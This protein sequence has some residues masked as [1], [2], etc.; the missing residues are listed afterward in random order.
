M[1]IS[2]VQSVITLQNAAREHLLSRAHHKTLTDLQR[3]VTASH[4]FFASQRSYGYALSQ[5]K[6]RL[7]HH[8]FFSNYSGV[9]R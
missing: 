5:E 1:V 2:S 4:S 9:L 7:T 6:E 8:L 3:K